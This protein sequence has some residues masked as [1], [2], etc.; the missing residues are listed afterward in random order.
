[1]AKEETAISPTTSRM[2]ILVIAVFSLKER[3]LKRCKLGQLLL[4]RAFRPQDALIFLRDRPQAFV[5]E[6]LHALSAICLRHVDV[7]LR[8]RSD[9]VRAVEFTGLSSA[10]PKGRQHF[11]CVAQE[12]VD[13]VVLPLSQVDV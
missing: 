7:A 1:M 13:A 5:N 12:D 2:R 8:I 9:A 6:L 11:E 10:F 4:F 3:Y